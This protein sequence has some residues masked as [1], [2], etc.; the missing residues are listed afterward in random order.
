MK[1]RRISV[2]NFRGLAAA[3]ISGIPDGVSVIAGPNEEGKSTL[4]RAAQAAFFV[5]HSAG[6]KV[7]S[8]LFPL[9][10]D[11]AD[12]VAVEVDFERGGQL[13]KLRK[14]FRSRRG[15][16]HLAV[17]DNAP[18]VGDGAEDKL[19]SL[20]RFEHRSGAEDA[21]GI[22]SLFWAE[23]GAAV[24]EPGH[25]VEIPDD[26]RN[27]LLH[28]LSGGT[29]AGRLMTAANEARA[30][31]FTPKDKLKTGGRDHESA[32]VRLRRDLGECGKGIETAESEVN[33]R[34]ERV[35]RLENLEA[36]IRER[37]NAGAMEKAREK[38]GDAR[39]VL[40]EVEKLKAHR[41]TAHA[42]HE[43]AVVEAKNAEDETRRRTEAA[44]AVNNVWKESEKLSKSAGELRKKVETLNESVEA[45]KKKRDADKSELGGAERELESARSVLEQAKTRDTLAKAGKAAAKEADARK[46]A[47]AIKVTDSVMKELR[48]T[49]KQ[50]QEAKTR[51]EA[52]A[53]ELI[54]HPEQGCRA[55]RDGEQMPVGR[56]VSVAKNTVFVLE[57]FG[58]VEVRPGGEDLESRR[59]AAAQAE[60]EWK[61]ALANAGV[62]DLDDAENKSRERR[63]LMQQAGEAKTELDALAPGGL[64]EM[65]K[66]AGDADE[67]SS[68]AQCEARLKAAQTSLQE[69]VRA[70]EKSVHKCAK[71]EEEMS[72]IREQAGTAEGR[73]QAEREKAN[74]IA[75]ELSTARK[76]KSDDA[77]RAASDKARKK[78]DETKRRLDAANR[79]L[80]Q[81]KPDEMDRRF[82]ESRDALGEIEKQ[83]R[84]EN[85]EAAR[86]R[87][88]LSHADG[89]EQQLADSRERRE[90]LE[91][92]LAAAE[93]EAAA[94]R[95]LH[96]ALEFCKDRAG[97]AVFGKVRDHLSPYLQNVFGKCEPLFD[98][99]KF[100]L[101]GIR[102]N[103]RD[104]PYNT[105]SV[106]AR[107]QIS[108]LVRLAFAEALADKDEPPVVILDDVM[109]NADDDRRRAML[110][111][112]KQA[113]QKIQIIILTCRE[114]DYRE[115]EAP[116]FRLRRQ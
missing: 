45:A 94:A 113:A 78:M 91:K 17:P 48:L 83:D 109:V 2:S 16:V 42:N 52:A 54:F 79:E 53:A 5:K 35:K 32:V 63:E 40:Q 73:A 59:E 3:E 37:K 74:Q 27:V 112:L 33:T 21:L 8:S 34:R 75:K 114:R 12:T 89:A 77:L 1:L 110:G 10:L 60:A 82:N 31:H 76:E 47:D 84:D 68:V 65:R 70:H 44:S 22:W 93:R 41:E 20:L 98:E 61:S 104:E 107:E 56:P 62:S 29:R 106:G 105:L 24:R 13:W 67:K 26:A 88:E 85:E 115:L 80:A 87:G 90:R 39:R 103:G 116:V 95:L 100:D 15:D 96:R 111:A 4:L 19:Q 11:N 101:R 38:L 57:Q 43:R 7:A 14:R 86:L 81:V 99:E 102:R 49:D 55:L 36:E 50:F 92:E 97:A 30:K 28:A 64:D 9:P 6:G 69:A 72:R 23:Q 71:E 18:L 58:K 46:R 51:L 108:A 66:R 25:P